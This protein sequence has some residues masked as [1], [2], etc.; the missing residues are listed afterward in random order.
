M[1]SAANAFSVAQ[2]RRPVSSTMAARS[3]FDGTVPVLVETPP[4]TSAR[5]TIAVRL[6]SFAA[7]T[8]ARW[9]AGPDPMAMRS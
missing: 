8:A 6:P 3:V 4:S 1:P 5:S 2:W 7:W 9:P